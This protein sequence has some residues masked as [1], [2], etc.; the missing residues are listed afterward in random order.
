[1]TFAW[2]AALLPALALFGVRVVLGDAALPRS[3]MPWPLAAYSV[4][5]APLVETALML[6]F[7][8]LLGRTLP[9]RNAVHVGVTAVVF[10]LLHVPGGGIAQGIASAWP[11]VVYAVV[12]FAWLA[13]SWAHAFLV[14]SAVHALYNASFVAI[15]AV[16]AARTAAPGG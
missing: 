4:V 10:A 12:L 14:T 8:W 2:L 15:G 11:F 1:L 5:V 13:R 9:G 6:G 16:A 3:A 7:A